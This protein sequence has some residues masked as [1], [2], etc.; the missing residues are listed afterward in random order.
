MYVKCSE[1][2]VTAAGCGH[3]ALCGGGEHIAALVVAQAEADAA[4]F[5]GLEAV[6]DVE[7]GSNFDT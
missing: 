4:P 3:G 2:V 6:G 5:G 1:G 7:H